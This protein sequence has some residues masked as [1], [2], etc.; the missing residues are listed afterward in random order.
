[1]SR[2]GAVRSILGDALPEA[3]ALYYSSLDAGRP[4]EAASS[5][6]PDSVYAVPGPGSTESDP[7]RVLRG[8]LAI[9]EL[10]A[11]RAPQPFSHQILACAVNDHDCMLEGIRQGPGGEAIATFV[12]SVTLDKN[13]SIAR[14]LAFR[15]EPAA[16]PGPSPTLLDSAPADARTLSRRYFDQLGSGRVQEAADCFSED[17]LYSH[18]PYRQGGL[19]GMHRNVFQGRGELL[20]AFEKRGLTSYTFELL[21]CLQ[22]GRYSFFEGRNGGLADGRT[23]TFFSSLSVNDQGLIDRYVTFYTEPNLPR[24]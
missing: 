6:S 8:R 22:S 11:R 19:L 18:P 23:S 1:V 3:L 14:Y 4:T 13:L 24:R 21:R 2:A 16:T 15:C 12:A 10:F 7:L 5:F 20:A 17:V 9:E